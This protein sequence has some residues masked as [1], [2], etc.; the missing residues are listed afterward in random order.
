MKLVFLGTSTFAVP[1]LKA[2]HEA[3]H[4]ICAVITMPDQP[5]GRKQVVTPPAIKVVAQELE[6]PV[7][8]PA[9]LKS[10]EFFE[11]FKSW[12]CHVA[13]VAAYGKI[14]PE[15]YLDAL[16]HGFLNIHPSL[17]PK[18]R[19]PSPIQSAIINGDEVMGVT[20]MKL[21]KGMDTGP[22]LAQ[23][24]FHSSGT[25]MFTEI[26]D[27]LAVLGAELLIET[28]PEYIISRLKPAKQDD[29]Q[30]TVTKM[31]TREDGHI[32]WSRSSREIYNLIRALN[33]E[34]GTWT[35]WLARRSSGEGGKDRILNIKAAAIGDGG[36]LKLITVQ[37]EGK[38]EAPFAEFINGHRDFKISDLK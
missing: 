3:G 21:D 23:I 27:K 10:D 13:V 37:L 28:I 12:D 32:N 26:H 9:T 36:E 18:Y 25:E 24:K 7:F 1:A 34:P 38:K 16:K 14:I 31:L 6:L 30:A 19:G 20:I 22:M 17:L 15:R 29:K 4:E 5:V 33:P 8:Q 11:L 2:L 35:T